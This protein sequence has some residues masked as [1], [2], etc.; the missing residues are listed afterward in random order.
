MPVLQVSAHLE[1]GSCEMTD[2]AEDDYL[3]DICPIC[4]EA[5]EGED[6]WTRLDS[7]LLAHLDCVENR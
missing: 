7:G 5:I 3:A 6:E 1:Q 2:S 4:G